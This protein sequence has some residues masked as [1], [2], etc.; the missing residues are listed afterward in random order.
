MLKVWF[1]ALKSSNSTLAKESNH[2]ATL[3]STVNIMDSFLNFVKI[4][5]C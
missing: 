1:T 2:T 4:C 5:M 3:N